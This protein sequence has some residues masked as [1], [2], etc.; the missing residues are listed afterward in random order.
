MTLST[1]NVLQLLTTGCGE[2]HPSQLAVVSLTGKR[3]GLFRDVLMKALVR[4]HGD[5]LP[6]AEWRI[7]KAAMSRWKKTRFAGDKAQGI[8]DLV[9]LPN[10]NLLTE[11]PTLVAEFKLWYWFDALNTKKYVRTGKSNSHL[12]SSSFLADV[13]KL[14]AVSPEA[15]GGRIIVTVVP[16][17]HMDEFIPPDKLTAR[18]HLADLGFPYSGLGGI[19]PNKTYKSSALMR[20]AALDQ[21]SS[22]F[23]RQGCPTI[24]GGSLQGTHKG[25]RV[26]TDFV[27]SEI[28]PE[29]R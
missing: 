20:I 18:Q 15:D 19:M 3:E 6:R 2:I 22:Y 16:T 17:F 13:S 4:S 26:T 27:V 28:A 5:H 25:L 9:L 29:V 24:V 10:N 1:H 8:V 12:I 11:L 7:P 21:I 23:E 14:R